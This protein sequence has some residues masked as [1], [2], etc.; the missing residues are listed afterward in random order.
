M[1]A[2]W[3][4]FLLRGLLAAAGGPVILA[5]IY[6]ILGQS[7]AIQS[8]APAAVSTG[9]LTITL[10]A[11]VAAGI[12]AIYQ[13]EQLALPCAIAIHAVV[14]YL[15]YLMIYLTNDWIP[16]NLSAIGVF[17]AVFA[18][19]FALVWLLIYCHIR[20]KTNKLNRRVSNR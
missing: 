2:F 20:A 5:I 18:A 12:T 7:G 15:D 3:K 17:T 16:K 19:G 6:A 10:M 4:D 11:F 8:L 14:L 1:K 9:I 13:V